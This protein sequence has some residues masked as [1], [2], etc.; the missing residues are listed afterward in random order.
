M[1]LNAIG[2]Q[3]LSLVYTGS[4]WLHSLSDTGGEAT[5]A[6]VN[7]HLLLSLQPFSPKL[8]RD[9][10]ESQ[11]GPESQDKFDSLLGKAMFV[12]AKCHQ[13][14]RGAYRVCARIRGITSELV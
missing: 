2:S 6:S 11:P 1:C 3:E 8:L 13:D 4:S 10:C 9:L 12:S 7:M 14:Q 5:G